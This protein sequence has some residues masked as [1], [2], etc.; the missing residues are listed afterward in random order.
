MSIQQ[1]PKRMTIFQPKESVRLKLFG[2]T[3]SLP[4]EEATRN[5]LEFAIDESI[6]ILIL[7]DLVKGYLDANNLG[8]LALLSTI[9]QT[10]PKIFIRL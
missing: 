7:Y 8:F 1:P 6:D 9:E 5:A 2:T 4:A 10:L 3:F